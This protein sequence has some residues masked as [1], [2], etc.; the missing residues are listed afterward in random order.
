MAELS[1]K[2]LPSEAITDQDFQVRL[3]IDG[4]DILKSI[5]G[6][7]LGIDPVEFFAQKPLLGSGRLLIGRCAC[8]VVGCGDVSASVSRT[9]SEV[10][11]LTSHTQERF[12]FEL[13][14]YEHSIA[15]GASDTSWE[16]IERTAE[17]LVSALDY[18]QC[19][20]LGMSFEWASARW[21]KEK[22][23]LFFLK[24]NE[25]KLFDVPWNYRNPH[26]ALVAVSNF[27]TRL[28]KTSE[29]KSH[30]YKQLFPSASKTI[31]IELSKNA[32][33][34]EDLV[35]EQLLLLYRN[36]DSDLD[37][38]NFRTYL[39]SL[40]LKFHMEDGRTPTFGKDPS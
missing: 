10:E 35:E 5:D 7:K 40:G 4:Q 14:A 16:T 34:D 19:L 26:E 20:E 38:T 8:G 21:G 30:S 28:L 15:A 36:L 13:H 32:D 25:Q 17:R 2:F 6:E 12:V 23:T 18:S 33:A 11:W 29:E 37:H 39:Q 27:L 22:M 9:S 3:L 24:G 31:E 1:F